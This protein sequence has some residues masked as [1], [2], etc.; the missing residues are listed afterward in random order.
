[1]EQAIAAPDHTTNTFSMQTNRIL[2]SVVG[3]PYQSPTVKF[4]TPCFHPNV[5]SHGNICLDILKEK[6][7]ALYEV[8]N[9]DVRTSHLHDGDSKRSDCWS[10]LGDSQGDLRFSLKRSL[11]LHLNRIHDPSFN[12]V[13]HLKALMF[14]CCFIRFWMTL[15]VSDILYKMLH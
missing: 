11:L 12:M 8:N 2:F 1:M 4:T 10:L 6:W 7:S 15:L 14:S 3:Y 13:Y 9:T 5:D